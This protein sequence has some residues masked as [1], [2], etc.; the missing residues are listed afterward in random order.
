MLRQDLMS[1]PTVSIIIPTFNREKYVAKAIDSVFTQIYRDYEII[2]V[3]DGSN[4]NTRNSLKKYRDRIKYIYQENMG[5]S[6]A[7]NAGINMAYGKWIA[8]LDSDDEW[9]PEYLHKQ[10]EAANKSPA[11]CM[12]TTNCKFVEFSGNIKS[13]FELNKVL[14]EFADEEYLYVEKPFRFV[15]EHGPWPMPST[16]VLR[17]AL[18]RAGL[19]N[20]SLNI[21][22]DFDLLAR[23]AMQGPFGMIREEL[24]KIYRRKENI[25]CLTIQEMV[26]PIKV[27]ETNENIYMNL[28]R[29][30]E[31]KRSERKAL[32]KVMSGNRRAIGNLLFK[33]EKINEARDSYKRAIFFDP[34][35]AS[36]GK[37]LLSFILLN[38]K[39]SNE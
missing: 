24:V 31:L 27:R 36:L 16:M 11:L 23:V 32:N 13:Y 10:M 9:T 15:I 25:E 20:T 7:R 6:A 33:E 28:S 35:I 17:A 37:Y 12:Q 3:D 1:C 26:D 4:D 34:S 21:S 18:I 2:V 22:E 8:F 30:H 38:S 39:T 19:F 14:S 5:V 29:V